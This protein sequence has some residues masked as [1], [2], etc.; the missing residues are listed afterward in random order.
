V[1]LKTLLPVRKKGCSFG[2]WGLEELRAWGRGDEGSV[3][4][5]SPEEVDL[6]DDG[7]E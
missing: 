6:A 3:A 2:V 5:G 4:G 1:L 7:L